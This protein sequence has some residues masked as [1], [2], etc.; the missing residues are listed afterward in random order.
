MSWPKLEDNVKAIDI[1]RGNNWRDNLSNR[2]LG[3]IDFAE[4]ASKIR[5]SSW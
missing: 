3:R 1:Y 4:L 5:R 2:E